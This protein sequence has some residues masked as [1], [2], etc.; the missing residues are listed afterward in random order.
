MPSVRSGAKY[1]D[2]YKSHY[3][4]PKAS[5]IQTKFG[6]KVTQCWLF[7]SFNTGNK[8]VHTRRRWVGQFRTWRKIT[9]LTHLISSMQRSRSCT[10]GWKLYPSLVIVLSRSPFSVSLQLIK[11]LR[12]GD[13]EK[14]LISIQNSMN[15]FTF[16]TLVAWRK[17]CSNLSTQFDI[18]LRK[19]H[20][21]TQSCRQ[22]WIIHALQNLM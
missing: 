4:V 18:Y 5:V 16:S 7:R 15:G 2:M 21:S 11:I 14:F 19:G 8:F 13:M 3:S 22:K 10:L 9:L 1:E 6:G 20:I 17:F 12:L